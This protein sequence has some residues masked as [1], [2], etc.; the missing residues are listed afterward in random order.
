MKNEIQT[1]CSNNNPWSLISF[2]YSINVVDSR[3]IYKIMCGVNGNFEHY[4]ARL[5]AKDFIQQKCIDY[6]KTFSHV[7]K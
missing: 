6:F 7:I 5:V 4:K 3:W 2:Y 1:L